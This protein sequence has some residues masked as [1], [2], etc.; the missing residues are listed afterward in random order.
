MSPHDR[1]S[2]IGVEW[3]AWVAR[4]PQGNRDLV[5]DLL[6]MAGAGRLR[7]APSTT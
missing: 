4:D 2:V 7:P 1:R 5:A 3:G 6:A